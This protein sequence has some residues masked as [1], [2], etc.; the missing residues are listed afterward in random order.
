[1]SYPRIHCWIPFTCGESGKGWLTSASGVPWEH[2]REVCC[3]NVGPA[4]EPLDCF[5]T[6]IVIMLFSWMF[7]HLTFFL[8]RVFYLCFFL[9][10]SFSLFFSWYPSVLCLFKSSQYSVHNGVSTCD[11]LCWEEKGESTGSW[12]WNVL[13]CFLLFPALFMT[14][15][16]VLFSFSIHHIIFKLVIY[17]KTL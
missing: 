1:M 12:G 7:L 11:P 15:T 3:R 8:T 17:T 2:L 9:L 4:L 14:G 10:F 6:E 16:K 5:V 13:L